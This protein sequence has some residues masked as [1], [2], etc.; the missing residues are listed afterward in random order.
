MS[1]ST[2]AMSEHPSKA[3][4]SPSAEDYRAA[5]R[6]A[7]EKYLRDHRDKVGPWFDNALAATAAHLAKAGATLE[8]IKA[9]DNGFAEP[10]AEEAQRV[11]TETMIGRAISAMF[12]PDRLPGR[13][14]N[15][16]DG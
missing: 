14:R 8:Q 5:G 12:D 7:G 2:V 1:A 16:L 3:I 13:G 10:I 11:D 6:K 4:E 9:W 15:G